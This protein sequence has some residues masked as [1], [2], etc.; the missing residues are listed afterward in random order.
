MMA[1]KGVMPHLGRAEI[2]G[3]TAENSGTGTAKLTKKIGE[4]AIF[5][6]K[7]WQRNP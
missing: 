4:F 7:K 1:M 6:Q 2:R 5:L 3:K